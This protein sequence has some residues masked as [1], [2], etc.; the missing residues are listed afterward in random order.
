MSEFRPVF[1]YQKLVG[2]CSDF[3]FSGRVFAG[4]EQEGCLYMVSA[5][6]TAKERNL[7]TARIVSSQRKVT[8]VPLGHLLLGP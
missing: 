5:D 4:Q 3:Q 2:I 6:A 7:E 8:C 1:L